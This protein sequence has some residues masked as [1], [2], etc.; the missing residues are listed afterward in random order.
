M[1]VVGPDGN[2][3]E[4]RPTGKDDHYDLFLDGDKVAR[5]V[6]EPKRTPVTIEKKHQKK[7]SETTVQKIA[8]DFVDKGGAIMRM[9]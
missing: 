7:V 1:E 9:L 2:T 8:E 5:F 4:V 3:Y 6:L